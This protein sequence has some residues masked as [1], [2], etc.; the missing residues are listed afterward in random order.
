[1][2]AQRRA[3][4]IFTVPNRLVVPLALVV[5]TLG[6]AACSD[7]GP[8]Y[9]QYRDDTTA[10][11]WTIDHPPTDPVAAPGMLIQMSVYRITVP[12]GTVSRSDQFWKRV[13]ETSVDVGTYDMLLKNGVR[14]GEAP[15]SEWTYLKTILDDSPIVSQHMQF[16]AVDHLRQELEM[17]GAQVEETIFYVDGKGVPS[18]R[19]F[20]HCQNL[21]TIDAVPTPRQPRTVRITVCPMVRSIVEK[22]QYTDMDNEQSIRFVRPQPLYDL[23]LTADVAPDHCLIVA[24]STEAQYETRLGN[25]FLVNEAPS[26]KQETILIFVPQPSDLPLPPNSTTAPILTQGKAGPPAP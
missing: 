21:L 20:D 1:M 25:R 3:R 19:S 23:N 2:T 8:E 18:G 15:L 7:V 12:F 26:D 13:D 10:A 4:N 17:G 16:T 9:H 22:L 24:P 14:I 5:W 6:L 11:K